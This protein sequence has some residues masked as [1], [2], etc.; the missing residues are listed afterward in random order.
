MA[1]WSR[2]I[3]SAVAAVSVRSASA[4]VHWTPGVAPCDSRH[5]ADRGHEADEDHDGCGKARAAR[6]RQAAGWLVD[7]PP[8]VRFQVR[9]GLQATDLLHNTLEVEVVPGPKTV[10]GT[11]VMRVRSL[12]DGLTTFT[13]MLRSQYTISA[14][15]VN[16]TFNAPVAS[17]GTYGRRATLD[18]AYNAG[19]EF[20]IAVTYSGTAVS[21][22]FGSINFATQGGQPVVA[23]LSEPYYAGS[24]WPCKDGDVGQS[25]DN[26]DKATLDIAIIAPSNLRSVSN[27]LLQGI[28]ALSGGRSRY[29]WRHDYPIST[30]LVAFSSTP[31][32]TWTQTYAYPL[33]GGGSGSMPVEFNIYSGSN[34]SANRTAWERSLDMLAA[35]R[36][37]YGEYPFVNEKY[38][39]Y[40][41]PFSGGMEH[42][43]NSGQ[44]TFS[45]SVTAH[46]LAH[47][48]WG[49]WVTTRTWHD[50]W[51]NEGFATY[52]EALWQER[53][54]GST[55]LP[56][57]HAAMAS[58]RPTAVSDT[59]YVYDTTSSSRIFSSTY[60]YRKGAWV[61]HMLRKVLGDGA[62]FDVLAAYRAQFGGSGATTDDFA[63]VA[64]AISGRDLTDYFLQWV[65]RGGAP[66]YEFGHRTDTINGRSYLRLHVTQTQD[67]AWGVNGAFVMPLDIKATTAAG[68]RHFTVQ[69]D[70]RTD[71]YV[72]PLDAPATG[73]TID[74]FNW[75]LNTGK[76]A[77]AHVQGPPV[78]VEASPA[79]GAALHASAPPASLV[80][81]FSDNVSIPAGALG[82]SGPGGP[83]AASLAYDAPARRATLTFASGLGP[84]EYAVTVADSVS[85][86]GQALD[87]EVA[88]P[89]NPLSLPSGEGAPGG[90]ALWRF[91]VEGCPADW[92]GDGAVDFNDF[93]EFLND[94]NAGAPRADLNA[95]GVID[96]NDFLEF[97]NRYNTPCP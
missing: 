69:N 9:E 33:P 68:D 17:V 74:E 31:Y 20:T 45:E 47:Q 95:D 38:G 13:F 8:D 6:M 97:L 7:E 21:V 65:Y 86:F 48:W 16:G 66:A 93:L 18:R 2:F 62:F 49:D 28:D 51:L 39:I 57:L 87:G 43:T 5:G 59:V 81:Y 73:V 44:G 1:T 40:Q 36:G 23:S 34:T 35:F 67:P 52:G 88:D 12:S 64:S 32:V 26:A 10:S 58:R 84:G 11:N 72:L 90:S 91:R 30:Y 60:S 25:G 56:A 61:L 42:Q 80:V 24:W 22:G 19:E 96:F 37:V 76:T 82:V 3:L 46:E 50:I 71:H 83:V 15:V 41:F 29:R 27:G 89:V 75:V 54:P 53:K 77:E 70:A 92:N 4:Q 79:P 14:C 55:G 85:A 78:V 63:A 94:Y